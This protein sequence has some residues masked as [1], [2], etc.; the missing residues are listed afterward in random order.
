MHFQVYTEEKKGICDYSNTPALLQMPFPPCRNIII[1]SLEVAGFHVV[2]VL[3][4]W[5]SGGA[6][7][8]AEK[9]VRGLRDVLFAEAPS[10]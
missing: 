8:G 7:F 6:I 5:Y 2:K 4:K 1:I 9:I 10:N 3:V